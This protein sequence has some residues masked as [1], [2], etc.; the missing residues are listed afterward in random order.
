MGKRLAVFVEGQTEQIFMEKVLVEVAGSRNIA[1]DV[2]RIR[3][4]GEA[5]SIEL[6]TSA[7]SY[8]A[9]ICDCGAD[10]RVVSDLRENYEGL[11]REGYS[12][13][14]GLRDVHPAKD[15]EI[16]VTRALLSKLLPNG[17]IPVHL[18]LAVRETEAWFIVEDRHYSAIHPE[19]NAALILEHVGIDTSTIAAESIESPATTLHR[20]YQLKGQAYR[21]RRAQV[22]QTVNALDFG[23][24]H[25]QLSARVSAL[26]ELFGYVNKFFE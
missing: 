14:L 4:S 16:P 10:N 20:I 25:L 21:K 22:E 9:L 12:M 11:T 13:V 17:S 26:R 2:R 8:Y 24:L 3:G 23:R 5:R 19:L 18:V 7:A 15:S 1:L 6:S